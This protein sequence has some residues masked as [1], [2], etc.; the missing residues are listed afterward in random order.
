MAADDEVSH[1]D[2]VRFFQIIQNKLHFAATGH[3]AAVVLTGRRFPL[4]RVWSAGFQPCV[5]S[6]GL[7]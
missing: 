3:T 1:K 4:S 7:A 6:W 2:S 5:F